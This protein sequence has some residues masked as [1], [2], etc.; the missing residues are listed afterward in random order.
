M[1]AFPVPVTPVFT[2][3]VHYLMFR[4]L[5]LLYVTK[6]LFLVEPLIS[7]SDTSRKEKKK[8]SNHDKKKAI[9]FFFFALPPA[10]ILPQITTLNKFEFK[11]KVS[12]CFSWLSCSDSRPADLFMV[13]TH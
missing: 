9:H 8:K 12:N 5:P 11:D 6:A 1:N 4:S 2:V 3:A 13:Q 7:I 10:L